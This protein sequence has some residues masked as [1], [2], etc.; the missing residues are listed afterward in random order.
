MTHG[1]CEIRSPVCTG[2]GQETH[3][4]KLRSQGGCDCRDNTLDSCGACH[5]YVH[6][7]PEIAYQH[8][9]LVHPWEDSH[10]VTY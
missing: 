8:R 6:A 1:T 10:A 3:H 2:W 9:W 7:H 5:R 4:R